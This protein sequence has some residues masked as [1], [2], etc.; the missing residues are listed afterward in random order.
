M[1]KNKSVRIKDIALKARVSTGTVDRVLHNRGLVSEKVRVRVLKIIEELD[2][3]PNLMARA[4]GSKKVYRIAALIPHY[5][6]DSYWHA[7]K[8]GVE[9]AGKELKNYGIHVE[10]FLF[11]PRDASSF[12][13]Q[14][15]DTSRF[16]PDGIFLAPIFYREVLPFLEKWKKSGIPFVL[17][18]T[19]ISD[20][21]PL[22]YIGQDSYQSGFL[23]AKLI[24]Y[25]LPHP[26]TILT[27]HI[28]EDISNSAHLVKK[29]QGFRNY[30]LH[31]QLDQYN[32]IKAELSRSETASFYAQLDSLI[33]NTPDLE[34]VF[35]TTSR[36]HDIA[37]YLEQ[38]YIKHI[39]LVGYDLL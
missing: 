11:N 32:I 4:L 39:R 31:N 38:R 28:D 25:G 20:F 3:K 9:Q 8:T 22:S 34:A 26:C 16:N 14:A 21:D 2:Y 29:E 17:F 19:Q 6:F 18:N 30:F 1:E 10:Q 33:E 35:V 27:A 15:E 7:P 36:A 24:H 12:I 37:G 23:A 5:S 13:Q